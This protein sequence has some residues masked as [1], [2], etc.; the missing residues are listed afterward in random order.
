MPKQKVARK[1]K[2]LAPQTYADLQP[3]L[4]ENLRKVICQLVNGKNYHS[5]SLKEMMEKLQLPPQHLDIFEE[6]LNSIS[7]EGILHLS[8]GRYEVQKTPLNKTITGVI[9]VHFRGFGFVKPDA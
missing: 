5:M 4:Y 9:R 2:E 8:H 6:A 3:R 7:K 1:K